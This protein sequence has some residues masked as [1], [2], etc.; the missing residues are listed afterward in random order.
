M[1]GSTGINVDHVDFG[2]R[3]RCANFRPRPRLFLIAS[4]FRWGATFGSA[5][6]VSVYHLLSMMTCPIHG[7]TPSQRMW[8]VM[9]TEPMSLGQL[10]VLVSVSLR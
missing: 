8:M 7:L 5:N 9:V 3:A 4:S 10:A 6:K 1:R 2:G